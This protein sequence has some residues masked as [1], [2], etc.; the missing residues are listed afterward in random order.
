MEQDA[1]LEEQL[2]FYDV[3]PKMIKYEDKLSVE[4]IDEL[5]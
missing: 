2:Q 1:E 4:K 3:I 5:R